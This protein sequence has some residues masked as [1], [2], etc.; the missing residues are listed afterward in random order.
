MYNNI[1]WATH[2][3]YYINC[4]NY[5]R[6]VFVI[7]DDLWCY[8]VTKVQGKTVYIWLVFDFRHPFGVLNIAPVDKGE[9]LWRGCRKC[10][11]DSLY[12]LE[13]TI[14]QLPRG[15]SEEKW[16]KL[17]WFGFTWCYCWRYQKLLI[18]DV[19]YKET[20]INRNLTVI[21][22]SKMSSVIPGIHEALV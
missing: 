5:S 19:G 8:L 3:F 4:Y 17:D 21:Y 2:N 6:L 20:H 14:T 16:I 13:P 22:K 1:L 12:S 10:T 11:L 7:V 18:L 9:L 15:H